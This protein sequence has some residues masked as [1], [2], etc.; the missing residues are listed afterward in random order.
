MQGNN[1]ARRTCAAHQ[2]EESLG[3]LFILTSFS[4]QVGQYQTRYKRMGRMTP[5]AKE[6]TK[7]DD[8]CLSVLY[9]LLHD[10][11]P[12]AHGY[13]VCGF[14]YQLKIDGWLL[15]CPPRNLEL[16]RV[17]SVLLSTG[18][19]QQILRMMHNNCT[20]AKGR[21]YFPSPLF[22]EI[23]AQCHLC[24][25]TNCSICVLVHVFYGQE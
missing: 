2:G 3:K 23:A 1:I 8:E 25:P 17:L 16:A 5:G 6:L 9:Y 21:N 4:M 7:H 12:V 14:Y 22:Q 11:C 19:L 24:H 10:D 18:N 15:S 20:S 13:I